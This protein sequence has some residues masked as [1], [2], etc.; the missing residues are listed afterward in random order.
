T[1][2]NAGT[3]VLSTS[4]TP[5]DASNYNTATATVNL[6][7]NKSSATLS[8]SNLNQVYD[9]TAKPVTVISSP[10]GLSGITVLYNG[11]SSIPTNAGSYPITVSLSNAN[12]SAS[13]VTG[14]LVVAKS[15]SILSWATPVAVQQGT[16]LS[17]TQ[18][19]ATS[20]GAGTFTY[21]PN[22]GYV[23]QNNLT[24]NATF[25]PTDTVNYNT[26]TI[27]VFLSVYGNPL[28]NYY[29]KHGKTIYL[30]Q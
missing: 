30:N 29:I 10:I 6:T 13:N 2:L 5:T 26:Q 19:N 7:V 16:A 11:S 8:L 18:L 20:T 9:G 12:Y 21:S 1:L 17:A 4:F 27:S 24:L 14:T 23:V 28:K 22:F 3:Y 15:S 25:I